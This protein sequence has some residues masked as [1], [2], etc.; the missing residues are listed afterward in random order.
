M[1]IASHLSS[2]PSLI[3]THKHTHTLSTVSR[4]LLF[5]YQLAECNVLHVMQHI[6]MIWGIQRRDERDKTNRVG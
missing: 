1:E 2:S 3:D 6:L 4:R 5:E